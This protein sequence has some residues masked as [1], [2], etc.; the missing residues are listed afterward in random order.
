MIGIIFTYKFNRKYF[1]VGDYIQSLAAKDNLEKLGVTEFKYLN[2]ESLCDYELNDN[3]ICIHNGWFQHD[4]TSF[5]F[6]NRSIYVSIHLTNKLKNFLSYNLD[7][8][9]NVKSKIV[10]TRDPDTAKFLSKNLID[11]KMGYCLTLTLKPRKIKKKHKIIFVDCLYRRNFEPRSFYLTVKSFLTNLSK[12]FI[13]FRIY[14]LSYLKAP[15]L[16][17]TELNSKFQSEEERF[18]L[19]E[20]HLTLF[21]SAEEVI[22][23]RI[24]CA[25]PSLGFGK[26]VTYLHDKFGLKDE[27]R[28]NGIT[29]LFDVITLGKL[30]NPLII[31]KTFR[32]KKIKNISDIKSTLLLHVKNEYESLTN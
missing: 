22:T 10:L 9:R 27:S 20:E 31:R 26:K 18:N 32:P 19:A 12:H 15:K 17:S 6:L 14:G 25:L 3:E 24:H 2:R 21:A 4:E 7:R 5:Y 8:L 30:W 28:L 23:S 16:K 13:L 29:D 1:N 11:A